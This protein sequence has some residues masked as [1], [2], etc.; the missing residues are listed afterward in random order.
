MYFNWPA[1][2]I[3]IGVEF[4]VLLLVF[5]KNW[6]KLLFFSIVVNSFTWPIASYLYYNF[7]ISFV[8]VEIAVV[9]VETFLWSWLLK[10]DYLKGLGLSVVVNLTTALIGVVFNFL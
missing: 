5:R 2:V 4:F 9:I 1:F 10:L 8:A 7:L 3:T 6:L